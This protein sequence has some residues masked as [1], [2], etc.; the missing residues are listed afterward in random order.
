MLK[1]N[2]N[3][4]GPPP[5]ESTVIVRWSPE[6]SDRLAALRDGEV[7]GI[8]NPA[9]EDFPVIA[10][11]P[12][13]TLYERPSTNVFYLGINNTVAP[14]DN[15]LVRQAIAYA[16]DREGIVRDFYPAGSLPADQFM[17]PSIFGY[18]PEAPPFQY[19][20]VMAQQL[21][22]Q[23]GVQ[24][25][26][27]ATLSYA[28]VVRSYL[29]KPEAIAERIQQELAAVGIDT[30]LDL[31]EW[32]SYLDAADEGKLS[33]HLL[34]WGADYPDA[35]NF[36]DYHFGSGASSQFGNHLTDITQPLAEAAHLSDASAR[37]QMY[38]QAN[39]AIH[40]LV[41]MV[42]IAHATSGTAF[43]ANVRGGHSSPLSS[44][45]FAV[46]DNP[47]DD[48]LI[49]MQNAEPSGLYC[50]DESDGELLRVCEQINESLLAY[51]IG[52]TRVM[53]S[54][55]RSYES[56]ADATVWTFHLRDGVTFHDGTTLDANDVVMS[57]YVQWDASN[58]LHVGR[59]GDFTYFSAFFGGFLN[60]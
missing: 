1:A 58:P 39:T 18:T 57:Y 33:L 44:E 54:L 21:L 60:K 46:M 28:N 48:N 49:W 29:P 2:P 10:A 37:Y 11:D 9:P 4:W 22:Q 35:T 40:N 23:S 12:N 47:D 38:V 25:P 5:I 26:I 51:E 14:F 30:Q 32:T 59:T 7:D 43:H 36:L 16:I 52:G 53:P 42:A 17:P 56:N 31:E 8:D 3:Y 34:G 19:N 45:Y 20:P 27:T 24:L 6:A 41:P 55:A 15:Q 13:L 50:A